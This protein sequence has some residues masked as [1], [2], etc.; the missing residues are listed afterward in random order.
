[1]VPPLLMLP[2]LLLMLPELVIINVVPEEMVRVSPAAIPRVSSISQVFELL[3]QLGEPVGKAK[4]LASS[5]TV[6]SSAYACWR[7]RGGRKKKL[8]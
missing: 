7:R 5:E 8:K 6:K 2:P 1:M 4:Q 3:S